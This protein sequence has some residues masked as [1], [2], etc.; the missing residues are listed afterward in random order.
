MADVWAFLFSVAQLAQVACVL[1]L[2]ARIARV[3]A[4]KSRP[5][6]HIVCKPGDV[7]CIALPDDLS[8]DEVDQVREA[9]TR[10]EKEASVKL[11]VFA[12]GIQIIGVAQ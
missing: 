2:P 4:A 7:V 11:Q 9:A 1:L 3:L 8:A 6:S 5:F 10:F 12:D